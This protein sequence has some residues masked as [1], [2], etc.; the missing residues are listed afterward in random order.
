M[1]EETCK[2]FKQLVRECERLMGNQE[3]LPVTEVLFK[4]DW[5]QCQAIF[6][7]HHPGKEQLREG[8]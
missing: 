2:D 6:L 3:E 5:Q 8:R 1:F 4:D 7:K